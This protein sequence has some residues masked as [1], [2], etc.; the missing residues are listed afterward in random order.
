VTSKYIEL[1]IFSKNK[2]K[3]TCL[4]TT[5]IIETKEKKIE[6]FVIG[7]K[8]GDVRFINIDNLISKEKK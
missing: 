4:K 5:P 1:T 8:V 6:G 2:K 7:D 3:I